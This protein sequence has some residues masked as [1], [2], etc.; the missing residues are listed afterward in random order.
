MTGRLVRTL[1]DGETRAAG[2]HEATWDGQDASGQ[3]VAAG[4]YVCRLESGGQI[5]SQRLTLVK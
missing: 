5:A 3:P 1:I 2:P 4:V